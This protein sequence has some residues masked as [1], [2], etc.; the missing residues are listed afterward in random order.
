MPI[1]SDGGRS[2]GPICP[3]CREP[4]RGNLFK[5]QLQVQGGPERG[6]R[7]RVGVTYCGACGW[8]LHVD[9]HGPAMAA[10]A[11]RG[12]AVAA[13]PDESTPEGQFQLRCR[14]LIAEIRAC[15]F[16][17]FV[18]VGLI[19]DLG[20]VTAAKTI[21]ADYEVLPVTAWLVARGLPELTLEAEVE[22]LRWVD[23]FDEADR[24]RAGRRLASATGTDPHQ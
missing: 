2:G 16:D 9:A 8:T 15:G 18:W 10:A 6:P 19:N 21:L 5:E 13:P 11:S 23:V 22:Q 3:N 7:S 17:P 12:A 4:L 1:E 20:A 14:E 24:S